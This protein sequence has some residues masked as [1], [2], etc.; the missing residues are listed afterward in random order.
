MQISNVDTF[1]YELM[2]SVRWPPSVVD[3]YGDIYQPCAMMEHHT[4]ITD[5]SNQFLSLIH[6]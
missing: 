2:A 3:A 1:V 5:D 6:I 4:N